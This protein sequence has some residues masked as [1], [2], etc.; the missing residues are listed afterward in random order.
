MVWQKYYNTYVSDLH[1]SE[2][3]DHS[4]TS[5]DLCFGWNEVDQGVWDDP[6][7]RVTVVRDLGLV[8]RE[9]P[10]IDKTSKCYLDHTAGD[11][12]LKQSFLCRLDAKTIITTGSVGAREIERDGETR[13]GLS[14]GILTLFGFSG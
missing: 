2:M 1:E 10:V 11:S 14:E 4:P 13:T 9:R 5:G 8:I 12:E 6:M 7:T 3:G